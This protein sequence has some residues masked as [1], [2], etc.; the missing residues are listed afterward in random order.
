[1][2]DASGEVLLGG[3]GALRLSVRDELDSPEEADAANV[4]DCVQI[5]QLQQFLFKDGGGSSDGLGVCRVHEMLALHTGE[6]RASGC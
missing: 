6:N 5:L 4:S 3:K 1:M 2:G